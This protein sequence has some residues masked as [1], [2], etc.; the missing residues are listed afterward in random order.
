MV[1]NIAIIELSKRIPLHKWG[2]GTG[3][4]NQCHD[5]IV[6]EAPIKHAEWVKI[7]IEECLN[8]VHSAFANVPLT[9]S[10]DISHRWN[11]V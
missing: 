5:S 11:E 4:I 7:Q 8:M 2:E 1:M 3:I 9:A 6:V 10:A